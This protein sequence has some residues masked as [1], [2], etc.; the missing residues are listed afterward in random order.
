MEQWIR[1]KNDILSKARGENME[2]RGATYPY[3][4]RMGWQTKNKP[5]QIGDRIILPLY[6]DGLEMSLF[7]ITDDFGQNW[8]FSTPLA[9]I[10][11]IQASV[12]EKKNGDLVAYMRDNGPPPKAPSHERFPKIVE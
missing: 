4:R 1:F 7:A 9:G 10:A 11:N 2:R 6:S 12:A 3:F 5:V 8:Q